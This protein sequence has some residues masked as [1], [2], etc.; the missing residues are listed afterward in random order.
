MNIKKKGL[1]AGSLLLSMAL[2]VSGCGSSSENSSETTD[3]TSAAGTGITDRDVKIAFSAPGADHG[4][5]AAVTTGARAQAEKYDDV[6]FQLLEGTNESAGQVA[7]I[8]SLI[9]QKPDVLVI[10]PNEGA[11]LTPVAKKA[12]EAGIQVVNVD[13]T[14]T[15]PAAA[16]TTILGDNYGAG[17][18]A[19]QY[20]AKEL[21]CKGNVVEITGNAGLEVTNDRS[22]GFRDAIAICS[23][24]INIVAS[25]PADFSPDKGLT[26]MQNILQANKSIQAVFTH[27]DDMAQG[28]VQAIKNAGRD[29]EMWLTGVGG[30]TAAFN[31][32]KE[33]GL[34]RGTFIYNPQMSAS[35]VNLAR[36]IAQG[37]GM[38]DLTFPDVPRTIVMQSAGVFKDN[39]AQYESL[40][41]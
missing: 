19:G 2:V 35:A 16:R 30:S 29:K 14:F 38:E 9:A 22:R 6:E 25:Q 32:I 12:M 17:L 4:W 33:G 10:L 11:G 21:A 31:Q 36:L 5:L 26:V 27:D 24:G 39:V 28:V 34:Y 37:K 23:G 8:E 40:G 20:Y 18:L 13:R 1:T 3:T 7:Q 15:D 41:F